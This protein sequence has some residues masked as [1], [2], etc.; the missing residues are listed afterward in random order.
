MDGIA[1]I[2]AAGP[3]GDDAAGA[4]GALQSNDK[5]QRKKPLIQNQ[6]LLVGVARFELAAS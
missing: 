3:F 1:R 4:V 2:Y 5:R 6:G